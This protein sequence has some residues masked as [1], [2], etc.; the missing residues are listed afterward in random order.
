MSGL[1]V[2]SLLLAGLLLS[3]C[4]PAVPG[5]PGAGPDSDAANPIPT[6]LWNPGIGESDGLDPADG[7]AGGG[8]NDRAFNVIFQ[9]D[10]R[11]VTAGSTLTLA[12]KDANCVRNEYDGTFDL[13]YGAGVT[14][15]RTYADSVACSNERSWATWTVTFNGTDGSHRS[16]ILEVAQTSNVGSNPIVFELKCYG[17]DLGCDTFRQSVPEGNFAT[18][19]TRFFAA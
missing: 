15:M 18:M 11:G 16:A 2:T 1:G 6:E 14:L 13:K 9:P 10:W 4:S 5:I 8:E 3:G 19:Q 12:R 17:G 7:D